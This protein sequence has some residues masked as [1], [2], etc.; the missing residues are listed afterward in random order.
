MPKKIKRVDPF[1]MDRKVGREEL[2]AVKRVMKS[3]RLTFMSGNEIEEFEKA[4][5]EY[6][7]SK[8]AIAVSSGTAALH[9][10]LA[11][12]DTIGAGDEVL[13]PAYTFVATATAVLHQN[14]IPIFVD[15]D[16]IT[17]C[18]DLEDAKRKITARTK[19]IIPVH[20]FGHPVDLEPF[21]N[22]TKENNLVLIEDACQA[23]G[24]EYKGKKIGTIGKAG[25]FSL[26]ESKNMMTGE[27]GIIVTDDKE[28]AER[29]RLIRHH[30]EPSW[31]TYDRLGF[32][33][34]M[35]TIQ[36]AIG[37][38]QLKKLD[39]MNEGRIKNSE[40]LNKLLEDVPGIILPKKPDYG[41]HVYHAYAIKVEPKMLEMT[42]KELA[43]LLNK[44]FQ[45]TQLIYPAGLYT[46]KLFQEKMG[47]GERKC[48][49]T[50]P[51]LEKEEEYSN[52]QCPMVDEI[53]Q[54]I[55]GLPNWHQLSN[56]ELSLIAGKFLQTIEEILNIDLGIENRIIGTMLSS[57][58]FPKVYDLIGQVPK[59]SKP[60]KVAV[61]GFGG[62][63]QVHAISYAASPYTELHSI[64]TRNQLALHGGGLFFG[65]SNL[66]QD[67][68]EA[69]SDPELKA[70]SICVPTYVHKE[71]IIEAARKGKHILCE[72]PVLLDPSDYEE[73]KEV[74]ENHKIKFMVAMIC[75][76]QDQYRAA[77][78]IIEKGEIGPIVSVHARRRGR[79][80]PTQQ[81]FWDT[82]KSG[83]VVVD[84]AIHDIDMVQWM[85]KDDPIETVYAIGS[86]NVYPEINTWDTVIITMKSKRG[87]LVTIEASWAE[88]DLNDQV[89]SNTGM[90]INGEDGKIVIDPSSVTSLKVTE[91][92]GREPSFDEIDQ[93]PQFVRQIDTFAQSIINDI[94]V[95]VPLEEGITALKI[96]QA[97]LKS[98]QTGRIVVMKRQEP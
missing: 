84:L 69:L 57:G 12:A 30:G 93:L 16:P 9:V 89:G 77:K 48:P 23:H 51:F 18:M 39:K 43:D 33:Y 56:V 80:P 96:A 90:T 52:P 71:Y 94:P 20:L 4:F 95:P 59:I 35:T 58:I 2:L 24:A 42:G 54:N 67:Y 92:D 53:S 64:A 74:I 49:F 61:L 28:F 11:A 27:G 76:F 63:G 26:F 6:M 65:V 85:L 55:I 81:W 73:I 98:L 46:S 19:A 41:T 50:C 66:Y 47:Y 34:R 3:K 29:C 82:K 91:L 17:F 7:G 31:Y 88:A 15:I 38:E 68:K 10:A 83:G 22:L 87:V 32:N 13:V 36:A 86:N 70:V 37:I 8:Y 78:K 44:D 5:A 1:P 21:I 40:Y 79:G 62:I 45:I 25:C 72:K 14:A 75:R 60:I 97:A